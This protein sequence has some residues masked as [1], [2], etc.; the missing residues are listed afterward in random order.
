MI[1]M[2][3]RPDKTQLLQVTLGKNLKA[4]V[5]SAME[6]IPILDVIL[7]EAEDPS[8]AQQLAEFF[9]TLKRDTDIAGENI[10]VVLPDYLFSF[11][12]SVDYINE[13]NL[14]FFISEKTDIL[15]D[16]LYI[17]APVETSS[18]A[19]DRRSVYAIKKTII[20]TIAAAYTKER[21]ALVSIEPASISFLRAYGKYD[22][23]VPII[24][25]FAEE[26]IIVTYSPAG[27]I[28]GMDA[29]DISENALASLNDDDADVLIQGKYVANIFAA[30][31]TY[32]NLNTDMCFIAL[33]ENEK[34]Q[35]LPEIRLHAPKERIGFPDFVI[36]SALLPEQEKDWLAV[37]GTV[38]Q[39]F[40]ELTS[41]GAL[42]YSMNPAAAGKPAF[43]KFGNGNLLPEEAKQAA[44]ARQWKQVILSSCRKF[45][46]G[47]VA[48]LL[49]EAGLIGYFSMYS[50]DVGVKT[51][52]LSAMAGL[53]EAKK[54]IETIEGAIAADFEIPKTFASIVSQRPNGCG[55]SSLTIGSTVDNKDN[56]TRA[57]LDFVKFTAVAADELVFQDLRANLSEFSNELISPSINSIQRD[58]STGL[59]K[60]AF[61][62]GRPIKREG[63]K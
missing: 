30:G 40:D 19:P 48:V 45:S 53:S 23:E 63:Q 2:Y 61:S 17:T 50:I 62:V 34:I 44:R 39:E 7:H 25:M 26:A 47:F 60:A 20:D 28:F 5:I 55:F 15:A 3:L 51:Q 10:Y 42:K 13:T 59:K 37:L 54:E 52:Y 38:F 9:A 6:T 57:A 36:N 29:T 58:G 4:Q 41:D 46:A 43:V 16:D 32:K 56:D 11:I 21:L 24:E 22:E 1:T 8:S 18:P 49:L 35:S 14:Q 27:G 12:E 31:E 33:S